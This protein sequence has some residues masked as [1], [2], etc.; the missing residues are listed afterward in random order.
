LT[1]NIDTEIRADD[2]R[3]LMGTA[4]ASVSRQH[5]IVVVVSLPP[6]SLFRQ[7]SMRLK[8]ERGAKENSHLMI[9]QILRVGGFQRKANIHLL[10]DFLDAFT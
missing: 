4:C 6:Q 5:V 3:L 8:C 2:S 7:H 10:T 9:D 1:L